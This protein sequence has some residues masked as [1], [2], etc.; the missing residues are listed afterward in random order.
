LEG[1]D[2]GAIKLQQ[3]DLPEGHPDEGVSNSPRTRI[4]IR[5]K[6]DDKVRARGPSLDSGVSD[7]LSF[8]TSITNRTKW[9]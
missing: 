1:P 9:D 5:T 2:G 7:E 6:G 8:M 4:T 3:K